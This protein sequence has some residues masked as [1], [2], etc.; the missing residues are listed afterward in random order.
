MLL[1]YLDD[2]QLFESD[3]MKRL[4]YLPVAATRQP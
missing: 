3:E 2:P 1:G 4:R